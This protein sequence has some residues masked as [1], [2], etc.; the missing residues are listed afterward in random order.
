MS[1]LLR[2]LFGYWPRRH[3]A[4]PVVSR[5]MLADLGERGIY[6]IT[7]RFPSGKLQTTTENLA[8]D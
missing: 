7:R 8:K 4:C 1:D 6:S 5:V 3:S 2:C